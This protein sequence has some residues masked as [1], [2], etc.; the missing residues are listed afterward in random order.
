[1]PSKLTIH[2]SFRSIIFLHLIKLKCRHLN[3]RAR[4]LEWQK[5]ESSA[6]LG[7]QGYKEFV[8]SLSAEEKIVRGSIEVEMVLR[9]S[10]LWRKFMG[11]L[12][13]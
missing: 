8:G 2:F 11:S 12:E 6:A 9:L 13:P 5:T 10:I 7:S 3:I 4:I 1:M